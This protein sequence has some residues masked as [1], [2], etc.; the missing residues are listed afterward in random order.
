M[1]VRRA[2]LVRATLLALAGLAL[3]PAAAQAYWRGGYFFGFP[4]VY[5]EPSPF[6]Y[7][8]AYYPQ[9]VAVAPAPVV[10]VPPP[11]TPRIYGE[12]PPAAQACYAQ[13]SVCPLD[14]PTA[15]GESCSCPGDGGRVRGRAN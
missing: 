3:L 6:S 12:P 10:A 11:F 1:T 15:V 13:P 9:P 14:R 2:A 7:P 5:V 4:G 8:P